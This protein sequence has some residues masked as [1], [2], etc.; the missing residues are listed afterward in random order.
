MIHMW[1]AYGGEPHELTEPDERN[2]HGYFE[3]KPLWDFLYDL[4]E[5]ASGR[6]WWETDFSERMATKATDPPTAA[7]AR[8]LIDRMEQPGRPWLWKDP[9]LSH[10]LDFWLQFW[11]DPVLVVTVRHPVDIAMSWQQFCAAIGGGTRTV[12]ANLLRWQHMA[13]Q[14]LRSTDDGGTHD[15]R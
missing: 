15:L 2:P 4:G 6:S 1:G 7:K 9:A 8:A 5:L 12:E 11:D 3:Y 14:V 13:L 10:F